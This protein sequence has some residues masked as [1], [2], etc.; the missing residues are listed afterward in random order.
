MTVEA[1]LARL[2]ATFRYT[3]AIALIG[4]RR[5]RSLATDGRIV[6]LARGLYRKDDWHG[7]EDLIEITA[8]AKDATVCL[9]SAL[10]RHDLI[11][12]IPAAIDIAIP[13]SAWRPAV[14]TPVRWHHFDPAT[15][16]LGREGLDVGADRE[17]GL[18]SAERSIIDAYRLRHRE[19]PD[20]AN[21]AL[22]RWLRSGGQP[23][24]LLGLARAF[25]R[26]L[27]VLRSTLE[28]LL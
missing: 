22:K 24:A 14:Q 27:P 28:V 23:S 16:R 5:L 19:G 10:A 9:R 25:P 26:T 6:A 8:K 13:R 7:D 1:A 2:P 4:E 20:L 15:F 3:E 21:E 12:D 18:Y 11:D 17:I